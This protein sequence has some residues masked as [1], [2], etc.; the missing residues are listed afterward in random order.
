MADERILE[1]IKKLRSLGMPNNEIIDNLVNIGLSK[2]ESKKLVLNTDK[3]TPKSELQE[4]I[5]NIKENKQKTKSPKKSKEKEEIPNDFFN[6][7]TGEIIDTPIDDN[8]DELSELKNL[9]KNKNEEEIN[10]D[11]DLKSKLQDDENNIY[12][13]YEDINQEDLYKK[14]TKPTVNIQNNSN[15]NQDI[16]QKGLATT[17]NSKLTE[18]ENKQKSI[19]INI[20]SKIESEI[21]KTTQFQEKVNKDIIKMINNIVNSEVGKINTKVITEMAKLKIAEAKINSKIQI[22]DKDKNNVKEL[23]NEFES[24]K[25]DLKTNILETKKRTDSITTGTEENITKILTTMTVKLNEKIKEINSTLA[26]QS[27][28]TEGLVK[29]TQNS[30]GTEIKKLNNFQK[31]IKQQIDPK[32]LYDKINELD[33]FKSKLSNRYQ[34]RFEKVKNEF[35]QKAKIAIK[36]EVEEDLS[37]INKVKREIVAKTDPEKINKKLIELKNMEEELT[38]AIDT[39]IEQ[40][41]KIYEAS[42]A[43]E[44]KN[45]MT[46]IEN[47]KT[48]LE[49]SV[50]L[51]KTLENKIKEIDRFK[52]QFI[53]VIDENIEKMNQNMSVVMQKKKDEKLEN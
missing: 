53:A 9:S 28:I 40:S 46:E 19:E 17:I 15:G 35:L 22:I 52:K 48:N 39:K 34:E 25:N 2:E 20:K 41:L 23:T 50:D 10:F 42:I 14:Y 5:N 1:N 6:S 44:F 37:E 38:S 26:L 13:K 4:K 3:E 33:D 36:N 21:Q 11:I 51:Q 32:R 18:L 49:K 27:K 31:D 47:Y 7:E 45:K 43:T 8:D 16:W 12:K 24:L 29:N 30:I